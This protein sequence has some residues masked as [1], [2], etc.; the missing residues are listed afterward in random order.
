MQVSGHRVCTKTVRDDE[1]MCKD[2]SVK[3]IRVLV[4]LFLLYVI[5]SFVNARNNSVTAVTKF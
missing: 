1:W 5:S 3:N 2:R 4:I